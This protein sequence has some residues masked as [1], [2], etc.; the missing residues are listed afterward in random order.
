MDGRLMYIVGDI[1]RELANI[2]AGICGRNE[3]RDGE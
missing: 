2:V 1:Q 3:L